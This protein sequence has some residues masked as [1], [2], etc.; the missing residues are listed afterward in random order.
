[1]ADPPAARQH[2]MQLT[3]PVPTPGVVVPAGRQTQLR[4]KVGTARSD[5]N[6]VPHSA[7]DELHT[8]RIY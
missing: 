6:S 8:L 2:A 3:D 1:M 7:A 5:R 4:G